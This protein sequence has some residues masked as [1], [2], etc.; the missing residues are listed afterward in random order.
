MARVEDLAESFGKHISIPWQR[1]VAGAQRVVM[2][3]YE[4]EIE[5][6]LRARKK[7]FETAT[8]DAGHDW[9]EVDLTDGFA[10]WMAADEYRD[11]Y[12]Q[13]PSDLALKLDSNEF[14]DYLA[15]LIRK[16]LTADDV[17]EN[18]VVAVLGV[19]AIFGFAKLSEVLRE[20]EGDIRGRLVVFFPGQFDR[21]N[22]RLLDARDGWNYL[23]VPITLLGEDY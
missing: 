18:T 3:V 6:T 7:L 10:K 8:G 15:G 17:T 4:R 9:R 1:M 16:A 11:A 21:N 14:R 2:I 22:Y 5:R 19:G 13:D 20:I 12:F 23:A